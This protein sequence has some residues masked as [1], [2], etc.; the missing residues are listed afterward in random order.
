MVYTAD[1]AHF[2]ISRVV[3]AHHIKAD[4]LQCLWKRWI[5]NHLSL[6]SSTSFC[7]FHRTLSV[8]TCM[9]NESI[10]YLAS[11]PL[12]QN[13][14]GFAVIM[15]PGPA[16]AKC[17]GGNIGSFLSVRLYQ[18]QLR[19]QLCLGLLSTILQTGYRYR[20]EEEF[21]RIFK[22]PRWKSYLSK[23]SENSNASQW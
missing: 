5:S 14:T 17:S 20:V 2:V 16:K 8:K 23:V 15:V 7:L 22:D 12:S 11:F 9:R 4:N 19:G 6:Y 13:L 21:R 10:T 1:E 3:S 18:A